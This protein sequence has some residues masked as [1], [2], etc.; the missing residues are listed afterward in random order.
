[1][2]GLIAVFVFVLLITTSTG[3]RILVGSIITIF[4]LLRIFI[5]VGLAFSILNCP[6]FYHEFGW[7]PLSIM[8][9]DQ[10]YSPADKN[11]K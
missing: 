10:L 2:V 4:N 8:V 3:I 9:G 6:Q 7:T 5:I 1:M 11:K